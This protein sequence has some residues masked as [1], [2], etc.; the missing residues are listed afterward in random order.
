MDP[1]GNLATCRDLATRIDYNVIAPRGDS[2]LVEM[3][4]LVGSIIA[5]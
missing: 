4:L 2:T 1:S 5:T 3:L